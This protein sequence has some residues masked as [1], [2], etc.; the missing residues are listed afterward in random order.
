MHELHG[1][2]HYYCY[3]QVTDKW[4]ALSFLVLLK[5]G[6]PILQFPFNIELPGHTFQILQLLCK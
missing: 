2:L 4:L 3:D 1:C 6:Y 5:Q